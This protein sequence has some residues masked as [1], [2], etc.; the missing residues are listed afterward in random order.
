MSYKIEVQS[1]NISKVEKSTVSSITKQVPTLTYETV[2]GSE[3][4][5]TPEDNSTWVVYDI[6]F[7]AHSRNSQHFGLMGA[8]TYEDSGSDVAFEYRYTG[9]GYNDGGYL[10]RY[11][12]LIPTYEGSR[13]WKFKTRYYYG[14]SWSQDFHEDEDGNQ[15]FPITTMYSIM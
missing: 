10:I 8:L 13:T 6:Q 9:D 7:T 15:Y 2:T 11:K 5:Y 14:T 3:I 4:I 12:F 1:G